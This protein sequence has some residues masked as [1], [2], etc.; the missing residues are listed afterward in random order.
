MGRIGDSE[1]EVGTDRQGR[2]FEM[3]NAHFHPVY[4]IYYLLS[5]T[6]RFFIESEIYNISKG[7]IVLLN[8]N[9]M[10]KTT[11]SSDK[12]NERTYVLFND[13]HIREIAD[14]F[15]KNE[16]E[17]CFKRKV[18]SIPVQR[19]DYVEGLL[20][21]LYGEYKNKDEFSH[22]LMEYYL[23][24]LMI[25]LIR[26]NRHITEGN[27]KINLPVNTGLLNSCDESIQRAA[28]YIVDNFDKNISLVSVAEYVN[29]SNTYFSKKFKEIT[30][31]GFKEYLL[32]LR[33]KKACELLL[34][35]KLTVTE[36]AYGSGFNDSNYFG[37][38][39]KKNKGVSPLQYR[40]NKELM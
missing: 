6:R 37:D 12:L 25:F 1:I 16:I 29:M 32:N 36:I 18:F 17:E 34:E 33:I 14:K 22:R 24:E 38:V 26:Y 5:G 15:G 8:K 21:K 23:N 11:Y 20:E 28:Q 19:R 39:F 9:I 2:Y 3:K 40:K 4:E 13:K 35:T 7:D 27:N 31:F 30:G 10:H